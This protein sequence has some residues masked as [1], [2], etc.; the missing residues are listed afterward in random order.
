MKRKWSGGNP[1][2]LLYSISFHFI[3]SWLGCSWFGCWFGDEKECVLFVCV[4]YVC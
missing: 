2:H 4:C 1:P 3:A